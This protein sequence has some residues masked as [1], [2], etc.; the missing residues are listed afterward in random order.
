MAWFWEN[1]KL[2][3]RLRSWLTY[4]EVLCLVKR[5]FREPAKNGFLMKFFYKNRSHPKYALRWSI[6]WITR[7]SSPW[8]IDNLYH[9]W[10]SKYQFS[11]KAFH[12]IFKFDNTIWNWQMGQ[13]GAWTHLGWARERALTCLR[14]HNNL[15]QCIY[16]IPVNKQWKLNV[17]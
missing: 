11:Q 9:L 1:Q 3:L 14:L 12:C 16:S 2:L 17:F 5:T 4:M 8:L 7:Y 6:H 15:L 13:R 10:T